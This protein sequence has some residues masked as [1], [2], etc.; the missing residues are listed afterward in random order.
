MKNKLFLRVLML[1]LALCMTV[2]VFAACATE[3]DDENAP[4]T[5]EEAE[6]STVGDGNATEEITNDV[7]ITLDREVR[8]L[9]SDY[10]AGLEAVQEQDIGE[11]VVKKAI[12]DRWQNV[13]DK[14]NVEVTWVGK[15]GKWDNTRTAFMQDVETNSETGTAYDAIICYNL[16]PGG[17]A[18]KNL[19]Q[20]LMESD[21]IDLSKPWWPQAFADEMIVNEV[22]YGIAENSSKSNLTHLHGTFFNNDL[23]EDLGLE[24]PYTHVANNTWTFETMLSMVKDI[25]Y[26][27]N[28]NGA[29]DALDFFGVVTGTQAKIETWFI[30]MGYRYSQKTADG[31]IELL[32]SDSNKMIEW[33]DRFNN[34]TASKDFLIYDHEGHTTAFFEERAVLYMTS[35]V[36]VNSM[37]EKDIQMNYGVVPVPK[38]SESQERYYSNVANHY[39]IWCVPNAVYD[40]QE[41]TALIETMAA[42]SYFVVAPM[43]FETCVKL[44]YAPDE[45]L[46]GMYDMVRDSMAFDFCQVYSF[47]F[48]EGQDPRQLLTNCTDVSKNGSGPKANWASQWESIGSNFEKSFASI[49]ALYGLG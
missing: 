25:G 32:M 27:K 36:M 19:L 49:L 12:Y 9:Y 20:N 37:I 44:R 42:E 13:Q 28:E 15:P 46:Y 29:K 41:S 40:F 14:L 7:D 8:I 35:L 24:D 16:L 3:D 4:A 48:A 5:N 43:Y 11:D 23:I 26:D 10:L 21:Y 22:L 1:L 45:R 34:A 33:I 17:M 38:G 47:A 39:A 2:S 31:G 18:S 30:G 6:V